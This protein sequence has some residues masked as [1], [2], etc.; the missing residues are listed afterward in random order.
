MRFGGLSEVVEVG[1]K[2]GKALEGILAPVGMMGAGH[3][4]TADVGSGGMADWMILRRERLTN[5]ATI[6]VGVA[7]FST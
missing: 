4:G 3:G 2:S 5:S 6:V 1:G 7:T